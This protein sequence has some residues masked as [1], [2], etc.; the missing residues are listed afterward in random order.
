[1]LLPQNLIGEFYY[2]LRTGVWEWSAFR[3]SLHYSFRSTIFGILSSSFH[4]G[5]W[6]QFMLAGNC[7]MFVP[8]GLFLALAAKK[9]S[10]S[11]L[12]PWLVGIPVFIEVVQPLV[13][14]SFDVDDVLLNALGIFLGWCLGMVCSLLFKKRT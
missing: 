9:T 14:R 5:S 4:A 1:M 12:L 3:P 13:C 6:V 7:L 11:K 2:G 8:M 10:F